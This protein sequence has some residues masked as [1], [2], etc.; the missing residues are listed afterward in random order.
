MSPRTRTF[1]SLLVALACL[2]SPSLAR[3]DFAPPPE[4]PYQGDRSEPAPPLNDERPREGDWVE[5]SPSTF[6]FQVGPALL[7]APQGPGLMTALD[8]GQR[9]VGARVSAAW[10]RAETER[11]LAAYS[12]ELWLDFRHRYQ[13]HPIVAAGGSYLRGGGV[14]A[15]GSSASAG[16]GVLRGT[17]EYELPIADADARLGLSI[18]AF[19]PAIGTQRSAPW[20]LAA[21]TVAAG[22]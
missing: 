6:R 14:G 19:V 13:L 3:A 4:S 17:L 11:G 12:A 21:L 22:F 5:A 2:A 15:A 18:M 7:L 16:A 9:A 10:L 8:V 20:T 1:S